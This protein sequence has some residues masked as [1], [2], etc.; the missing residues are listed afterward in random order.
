MSAGL[1]SSLVTTWLQ[2]RCRGKTSQYIN[3]VIKLCYAST[4]KHPR[5][6]KWVEWDVCHEL[7]LTQVVTHQHAHRRV[8]GEV[9]HGSTV[10]VEKE[11]AQGGGPGGEVGRVAVRVAVGV[12][13][14]VAGRV[15]VRVAVDHEIMCSILA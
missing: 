9:E 1:C 6:H 3:C 13:I 7:S 15:A 5:L 14:R 12:V 11:A 10:T 8:E 4:C 2:R